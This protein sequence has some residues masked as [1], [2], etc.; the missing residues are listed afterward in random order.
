MKKKEDSVTAST[1]ALKLADQNLK[2]LYRAI[3]DKK[4]K[5]DTEDTPIK[6]KQATTG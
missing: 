3:R 5:Q 2:I 1:I 4:A 6:Q